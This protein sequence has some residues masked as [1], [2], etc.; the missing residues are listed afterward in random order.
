MSLKSKFCPKC[1]KE[2][3]KLID[4]KCTNCYFLSN[5]PKFPYKITFLRCSS[6]NDLF[7]NNTWIKGPLEY[8]LSERLK[9]EIKLSKNMKLEDLKIVKIGEN[10]KIRI[11]ISVN[12]EIFTKSKEIPIHI[13]DKKCLDCKLKNKNTWNSKVQLRTDEETIKKIRKIVPKEQILNIKKVEKGIDI[14]FFERDTG[15][16]FSRK[17]KNK[18]NLESK[19]SFEQRG[20]DRMKN[21]SYKLSVISLKNKQK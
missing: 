5:K 12:D 9:Q 2:T 8:Y 14:Y 3:K 15:K 19:N 17:I 16:S 1:G 7:F 10:G 4:G 6:C 21:T 13:K 18:Y 20:W 11:W